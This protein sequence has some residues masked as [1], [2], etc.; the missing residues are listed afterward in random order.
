MSDFR[1]R[2][3]PCAWVAD[4]HGRHPCARTATRD[5]YC[6]QHHPEAREARRAKSVATYTAKIQKELAPAR[7]AKRIEE[8]ARALLGSISE[9]EGN[10]MVFR[11]N[12][13]ALREALE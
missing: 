10:L 1:F 6:Y 2:R 11:C 3:N 13:D 5:G 12:V 4:T 9:Y 8:A 7:R